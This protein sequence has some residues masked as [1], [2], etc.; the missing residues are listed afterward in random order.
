MGVDPSG[1]TVLRVSDLS[2]DESTEIL[3]EDSS[4]TLQ[5]LQAEV[6]QLRTEVSNKI[7]NSFNQ[8]VG[9]MY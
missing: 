5:S 7:H 6:D 9:T 2:G 8:C 3:V 4:R 1:S